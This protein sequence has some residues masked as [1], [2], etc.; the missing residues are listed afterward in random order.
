MFSVDVK[1]LAP[2]RLLCHLACQWPSK[3]ARANLAA[4]SDDSHSNLGWHGDH[5][6]LVSHF[7]DPERHLQLG[8]GFSN[9]SLLWLVNDTVQDSLSLHSATETSAKDWVDSRLES[10]KLQTT[11]HAVMPYD[12]NIEARYSEFATLGAGAAV[13]GEWYDYGL[14][15]MQALVEQHRPV[16]VV[17]PSVRCW[18]HHFDL[19]ALFVLEAGDPE[20]A[21]SIGVGLSPGDESFHEPY[22]YCSPYPAP[23]VEALRPPVAPV[24]WNSHG[25]VS[26]ILRSSDLDA[27][28][29]L[30]QSLGS[31]FALAHQ[32]L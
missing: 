2:A 28:T 6:A 25:F 20:T 15:G 18:P 23:D 4:E 10:A 22:F 7:L 26:L 14:Q 9:Q 3:A 11:E 1:S 8:F 19:G 21:R 13:L 12:L 17:P 32:H 16:C 27:A 5:Q 29:D 31:A 30:H 24:F